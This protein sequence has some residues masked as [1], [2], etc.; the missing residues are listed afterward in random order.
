MYKPH[1]IILSLRCSD[2]KMQPRLNLELMHACPFRC[3]GGVM[4]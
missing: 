3:L 1:I 4:G 2:N